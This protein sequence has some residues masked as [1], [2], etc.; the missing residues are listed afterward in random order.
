MSNVLIRDLDPSIL[1]DLKDQAKQHGRSMQAEMRAILEAEV[2]RRRRKAEFFA[3]AD[4][5][6]KKQKPN[7]VDSTEII[8][9]AREHGYSSCGDEQC[10]TC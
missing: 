7:A 5:F 4:E 10:Q 6:R 2:E 8:R 3:W 1:E 9:E